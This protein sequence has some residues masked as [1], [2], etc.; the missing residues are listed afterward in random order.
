M[1]YVNVQERKLPFVVRYIGDVL[2]YRH[3]LWNLVGS[4]LRARFRRTHLGILWALIQPLGFATV[5][6][7]V[8]GGLH[9]AKPY[10]DT[11]LYVFSGLVTYEM[12]TTTVIGGQDGLI[13]SGGYL[14][15]ARIPFLIF[16]MR[17]VLTG[18]VVYAIAILGV[19]VFALCIGAFPMPGPHLALIPVFFL[20]YL[21]FLFPI[22]ILMS[23]VGC[24][25][26]DMKHISGLAA[27]A[28]LLVSPIFMPRETLDSPNLHFMQFVDPI[29]PLLDMF[30]APTLYGR[31]WSTQDV[32]VVGIWTA[33]LWVAAIT[34]S[35][36]V[37]RRPVFAF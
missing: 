16:Q 33:G 19:L 27:Q 29:V 24:Y 5:I 14:Q 6:A 25:Y 31:F 22:S 20:F 15:Q 32:V 1:S 17:V 7:L 35:I 34:A 37:G 9:G 10:W 12:F 21:A 36:S 18:S 30:R 4:D 13:R 28:L 23:L 2:A 3:L 11:A 26:R 8:W